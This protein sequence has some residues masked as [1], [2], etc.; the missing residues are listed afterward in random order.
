MKSN[1]SSIR[2]L[3][4]VAL[5]SLAVAALSA[6]GVF[7]YF[8]ADTDKKPET[9]VIP[10]LVGQKF[11]MIG[12]IDGLKI[13]CEPVFSDDVPEGEVIS[14]FPYGG[15]RRKVAEGETCTVRVSVSLGKELQSIPDLRGFRYLDAA[16]ALRSLGARIR[17]VSI[18]DDSVEC[19]L[20]LRTSP[21]TGDKIEKGALVTLFV[22]RKHLHTPVQVKNYVGEPSDSALASILADGLVIGEIFYE[23]SDQYAAN[24]VIG[25]SIMEGSLVPY[26][27]HID[28]TLNAA[29]KQE[30]IHPFRGQ[31]T[32]DNEDIYHFK[33]SKSKE[34]G[35]INGSVD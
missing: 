19:D 28:I 21:E 24:S 16:S 18:Y 10:D 31:K 6:I 15:A 8:F 33:E 26:G 20:V 7:L 13:D 35:E 27:S 5:I 34:N 14:Q 4:V 32:S 17:V 23:V 11:D 1:K 2:R 29:S 3:A 12:S 22:S 9:I 25:Q 30:E